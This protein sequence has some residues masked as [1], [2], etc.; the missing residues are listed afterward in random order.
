[1]QYWLYAFKWGEGNLLISKCETLEE[2]RIEMDRLDRDEYEYADIV[3]MEW[4][5][6]PRLV[7]SCSFEYEKGKPKIKRLKKDNEPWSNWQ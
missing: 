5:Q 6:E 4:Q 3:R 7:S 2:A 1:M